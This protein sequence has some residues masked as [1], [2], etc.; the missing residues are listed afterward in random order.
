[1]TWQ[2]PLI[3][4]LLVCGVGVTLLC[5]LGLLLMD[6]VF[7]RLHYVGPATTVAPVAIAA[8]ILVAEALTTAGIKATL[9]TVVIVAT[10]PALT[11][12]T[13]RAARAR[14][15]RYREAPPSNEAEEEEEKEKRP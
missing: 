3:V 8:A 5:C 14:Q 15:I 12:A 1:M 9:I 13:A 7:T 4:A 11:H 6:D 2:S 10:S